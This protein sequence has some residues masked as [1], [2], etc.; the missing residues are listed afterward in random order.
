MAV[1]VRIGVVLFAGK[2]GRG[3]EGGIVGAIMK[4]WS[5]PVVKLT[6]TLAMLFARLTERECCLGARG[7][8]L[9]AAR[10]AATE[11]LRAL[12][13][14]GIGGVLRMQAESV[15]EQVALGWEYGPMLGSL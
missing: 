5:S 6:A 12:F 8:I 2:V 11:P 14:W 9:R 3:M 15:D 10:A 1:V 4:F 13:C 7:S